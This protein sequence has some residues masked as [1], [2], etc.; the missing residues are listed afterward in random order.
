MED[1]KLPYTL[2]HHL[3]RGLDY[4]TKTVFEIFIE[5]VD[6]ALGGGGRYDYLIE[7]MGARHSP[8]V[9]AA[10][11]L[12][13]L[14]EV[15]KIKDINLHGKVR[16]KLAFVHMGDL[17]KRKSL[18]L[19]EELREAGIDVVDFLGKDSLNSQLSAANKLG[20]PLALIFGQK[21]ALEEDIIIRDMKTGAQE[22]IPLKR[23][24]PG[25]KRKLK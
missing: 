2:N 8:A 17:A 11:G 9:G 6:F 19:I 16:P 1:L 3:V 15:V 12:E 23:I 20:S 5:G 7:M 18:A 14:I 22:T 21:E 25:I 4:Y 10:L 24:V 13:R